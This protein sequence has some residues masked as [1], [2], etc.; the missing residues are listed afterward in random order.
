MYYSSFSSSSSSS[1][2]LLFRN[3][4]FMFCP[5]PSGSLL[6]LYFVPCQSFCQS[7]PKQM[8][9]ALSLSFFFLSFLPLSSSSSIPLFL[10]YS[11]HYSRPLVFL[12][13]HS[14]SLSLSLL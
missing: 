13:L 8:T 9:S 7:R 5:F 3:F 12:I 11:W 2:H 14:L 1:S 4:S 10:V 6:L